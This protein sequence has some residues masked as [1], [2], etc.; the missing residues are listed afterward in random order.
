MTGSSNLPELQDK[1]R[2]SVMVRRLKRDVLTELP[3]KRRA[4][5]ELPANGAHAAVEAEQRA[6]EA[7]EE[8]LEALRVA[9]ELAKASDNPDDYAAAVAALRQAVSVAFGEMSRT[10]HATALAK[11]PYVVEH[12]RDSLE[13][14]KVVCFAHH[15]DVVAAI[16]AE[17]P[18]V[19][20][21]VTGD[22]SMEARQAAVDRFQTDP[23]CLLF[24]GNIQAAGVGLTLTASAHVVFAELDWV[25]G[26]VTQAEDRTH[27]IGQ[28]SAVLVQHLVLEGSLD[29]RMAHIL[30]EKQ[31]IIDAALDTL[32]EPAPVI[33]SRDRGATEDTTRQQLEATAATLTPAQVG[34]IT[35]GLQLLAAMDTDHARDRNSMGFS[36][37]DVHIGHSLAAAASLTPRQAALG[38]RLV[39]KYR[40]QLPAELVAAAKRA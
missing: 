16:M 2:G 6:Y 17:F 38:A 13:G 29:A 3:A 19:A 31:R 1:L 14:G 4:V 21:K 36:K 12:L 10:R 8:T 30:V 34:A 7:H 33:P 37:M 32:H 15:K 35:T 25:P 24:V 20:V 26:N 40:R 11:V 5:I 9:V 39:N 23:A 22:D 18:D 27:R 28:H